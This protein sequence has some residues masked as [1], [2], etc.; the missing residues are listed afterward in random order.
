M[1]LQDSKRNIII[2]IDW[3]LPAYKAG[4]PIQSVFNLVQQL[5][6][7][8]NFFIVTSNWDLDEK[9]DLPKSSLNQWIDKGGY[10]I[11][12]LDQ[13]HQ[14]KS[15]Y[16][17]LVEEREYQVIY[18]NSLF[19]KKF[20][21]L[22]LR[23]FGKENIKIVLAPRGML[24]QGALSIKPLKKKIFLKV[25]R[26]AGWHNKVTWH[27]TAE[28]EK[29]EILAKFGYSVK[30][31]VASNLSKNLTNDWKIKAKKENKL[32]LFFLSRISSKKNLLAAIKALESVKEIYSICFSIIG[33][34]EDQEYW[35]ACQAKIV[36]LSK[37]IN[38]KVLGSQPN[39]KISDLLSD[40]HILLLPTQHENFGHVIMESW[41][42]ACPVIISDQTPWRNL[43]ENGV[44]WDISLSSPEKFVEAIERAAA[45]N[46]EEYN[47]MSQAAFEFAKRFT[48]DPEVLEANRKLFGLS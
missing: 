20:T 10:Q 5:Q 2:F 24:G 45:M 8:Y 44:G 13:A 18:L 23:V 39:H 38:V 3:F 40:Q 47:K 30:I 29:A 36:Q 1:A 48:E 42:N 9:L 19:S 27:A 17:K 35:E 6:D 37:H 16:K 7:E 31:Q 14:K 15:F 21:L 46:Q 33:P 4:G 11:I 32:N 12:Y 25:F 41:Q 28:T 34:A 26:M 43:E 22:P